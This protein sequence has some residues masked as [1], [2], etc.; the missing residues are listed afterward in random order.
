[1]WHVGGLVE[2]HDHYAGAPCALDNKGP[3]RCAVLSRSTMPRVS[4][5]LGERATGMLAAG[6][7]TRAVAC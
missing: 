5:V 3:L 7:S 4:R 2:R 6:M 1:M